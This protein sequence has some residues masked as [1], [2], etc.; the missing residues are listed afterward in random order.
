MVVLLL[1]VLLVQCGGGSGEDPA[2]G[3]GGGNGDAPVNHDP[4]IAALNPSATTVAAGGTVSFA[5]EVTDADEDPVGCEWSCSGGGFDTTSGSAP[6]WTAPAVAGTY[7]ITLEATDGQG[8]TDT[9][10]IN[11]IVTGGGPAQYLFYEDFESGLGNWF[12][13]EYPDRMY[14]TDQTAYRGSH[15]LEMV[16]R[17][18]DGEIGPGWMYRRFFP[19]RAGTPQET[20]GVEE[21]YMRVFQRFSANWQWPRGGDG[22]HNL[23]LLAGDVD[24]LATTELTVYLEFRN[25]HP[26][27]MIC[28][29]HQDIDYQDW[30][31]TTAAPIQLDRWY[32]LEI[33]A[34]MNDAG[35]ANGLLQ[36]WLDGQLVLDVRNLTLRH[37]RIGL[38]G[39]TLSFHEMAIGP[40]YHGG[41]YSQQPMYVW[42]DEIAVSTQRIGL[43]TP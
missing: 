43:G 13:H 23:Y 14:T 33:R 18:G 9:A 22:P 40:W 7:L 26:L 24:G 42:M 31:A 36:V 11:I 16:F 41:I 8:G 35:Q 39:T 34:K 21:V 30:E 37:N 3:G 38:D 32:C 5:A 1:V 17:P 27:A 6:T 12:D 25:L 20:E 28:G 10:T 2:N 15:C 29:A 19:Q 4:T